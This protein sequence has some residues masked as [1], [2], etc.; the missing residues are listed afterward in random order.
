MKKIII[1]IGLGSFL[2]A[3]TPNL[4]NNSDLCYKSRTYPIEYNILFDAMKKRFLDS[5][6]HLKHLSKK[7]GFIEA[8]GTKSYNDKLYRF[9]F[10]VNFRNLGDVNK[11]STLVSY[12]TVEKKS[13]IHSVTQ[14]NLPIPIPWAKAFKYE[15]YT[16]VIDPTFFDSFYLNFDKSLFDLEMRSMHIKVTKTQNQQ[17]LNDLG[18][19]KSNKEKTVLK[20]KKVLNTK[21]IDVSKIIRELNITKPVINKQNITTSLKELNISEK[22]QNKTKTIINSNELNITIIKNQKDINKTK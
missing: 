3:I 21:K 4:V 15:G 14:F 7:D 10:T 16:N 5:N 20:T 18:E 22:E 11:I 13:E 12:E 9:T 17:L 2:F 19:E 1:S 8:E 6:M